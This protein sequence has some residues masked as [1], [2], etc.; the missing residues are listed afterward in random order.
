[1]PT[2]DWM[3]FA[4]QAS[5]VDCH[6]R[7]GYARACCRRSVLLAAFFAVVLGQ[8]CMMPAN[9]QSNWH[10]TE[11][12]THPTQSAVFSRYMADADPVPIVV[13][14][15][16]RN[17]AELSRRIVDISTPGHPEYRHWLGSTEILNSYAPTQD[18]V[19]AVVRYLQSMGFT[20]I[21]VEPNR[22]L[23][24]ANGT[25]MT[26]RRA[27]N[28][29]L[30]YFTRNGETAFANISD[31]LVPPEL[32]GIVL[33]VL[34][35]QTLD[36]PK[37]FTVQTHNPLDLAGIYD[38]SP[39][40]AATNTVVG[41]IT[42]GNMAP[43][44]AD[45]HTFE[46]NNNLPTINPTV[47]T[48][49]GGSNDT[50]GTTEWDLDSQVLQAM[51][52]GNVKQMILYAAAIGTD[53][54][55]TLAY[56]RAVTDNLAKVINVSLGNCEGAAKADGS[57][58]MDDQI[59]SLGAAQGQTFAVASGD[60][61][62]YQCVANNGRAF[63]GTYG[64]V[65]SDAYPA[66]SP[67]VVSV[68]G[69]TLSTNGNTTYSGETVWAFGG[70]GPSLYE[71]Q[72]VWQGGVV[73]GSARGVPDISFDADPNSSALIVVNGTIQSSGG[74]SQAAPTFAGAWARIESL[75]NNSIGFAAPWLYSMAH[76]TPTAF[77]DVTSGNNGHYS[78]ATGWD[79]AS[80][81]GSLDVRVVNSQIVGRKAA[82]QAVTE[83]LLMQ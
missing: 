67:Y 17:P 12:K 38:A 15:K 69:T 13:A 25:A 10:S 21:K 78:A 27:F 32:N 23:V 37:P 16:L 64:T 40:P 63:N 30:A 50:S 68:G 82:I 4:T 57:M 1:M 53:A 48:I 71:S 2:R 58:S 14:L 49:N 19:T 52:G 83:L 76:S 66:S 45:L 39:M 65:L 8:Q 56:N 28:T 41:I 26:A 18:Q 81:F 70:G 61:G 62:A 35:L 54:G 11:T 20:D 55:F 24:S 6:R 42:E 59:F 47:V 75:E 31:V 44:I 46:T 7:R 51:A 73:S 79:F 43:V 72:P 34:G 3:T 29:E 9:A 5:A 60:S 33:A 77:H 36:N 80:G 74:T 22:L